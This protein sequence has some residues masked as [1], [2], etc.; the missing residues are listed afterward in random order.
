MPWIACFKAFNGWL[1]ACLKALLTVHV[2]PHVV[3]ARGEPNQKVAQEASL[4][5]A[6]KSLTTSLPTDPSWDGHKRGLKALLTPA[7]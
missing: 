7:G 4:R 2:R 5:L 1:A 6:S 3:L